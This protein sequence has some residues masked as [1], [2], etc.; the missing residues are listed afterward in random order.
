M[1]YIFLAT[2]AIIFAFG[3]TAWN[4]GT[5]KGNGD[6]VKKNREI[7]EAFNSIEVSQGIDLFV[8]QGN[9]ISV[10][11]ESDHADYIERGRFTE[12]RPAGY[13]T[14]AGFRKKR[15]DQESA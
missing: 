6:I 10:V 14:F 9:E 7:T 12:K 15:T 13:S 2:T 1:K 5:V 3:L 4:Y 8:K 11:V